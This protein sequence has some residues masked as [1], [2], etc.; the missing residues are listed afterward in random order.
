MLY[1]KCWARKLPPREM[2][3]YIS[4]FGTECR[5]FARLQD[6]GEDGI[7]AVKCY[8]WMKLSEAQARVI[9]KLDLDK[10]SLWVMIKEV[11]S[12]KAKAGHLPTMIG[13]LSVFERAR[14]IVM[15]L[16]FSNY[17]DGRCLDLGSTKLAPGLEKLTD[18]RFK[19]NA[20]SFQKTLGTWTCKNG[21]WDFKPRQEDVLSDVSNLPHQV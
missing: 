4:S 21:K 1:E 9:P 11:V 13:N 19:I 3:A 8:G 7:F 5:A 15:D 17:G 16:N 6:I 18:H 12:T 20:Q 2:N 10:Y 14:F